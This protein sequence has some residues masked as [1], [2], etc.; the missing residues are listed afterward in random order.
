M[1]MQEAAQD[2][3]LAD[4]STWGDAERIVI[5]VASCIGNSRAAR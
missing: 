4:Y 5:N 2:I 1:T 3:S